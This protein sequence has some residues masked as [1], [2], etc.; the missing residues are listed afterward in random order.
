MCNAQCRAK[1]SAKF[2]SLFSPSTPHQQKSILPP[3][4]FFP[5]STAQ[6]PL[7]HPQ[8][9]H[10]PPFFPI[11]ALIP[12]PSVP[13]H[14]TNPLPPSLPSQHNMCCVQ[15]NINITAGGG[16]VSA[17]Y[18]LCTV[19]VSEAAGGER[20]QLSYKVWLATCRTPDT[21]TSRGHSGTQS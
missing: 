11:L 6:V 20:W 21:R 13:P 3:Q 5:P 16:G 14:S 4:I 18:S 17:L 2:P 7:H 9:A 15:E 12:N 8:N 10:N 19:C 1:K